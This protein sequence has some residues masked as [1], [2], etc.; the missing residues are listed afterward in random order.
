[1]KSSSRQSLEAGTLE[2]KRA[3]RK[4]DRFLVEEREDQ[5]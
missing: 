5:S 4:F 3:F 1:M 2:T